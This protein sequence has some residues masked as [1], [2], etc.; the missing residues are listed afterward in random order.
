MDIDL[1]SFLE[2]PY[3]DLE[4][5]NLVAKKK[6]VSRVSQKELRKFYTTYLSEEIRIKAVTIG[7]SDIEGRLH[8]LDY[9]KKYFLTSIP[10]DTTSV[11]RS[12]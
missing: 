11:A 5:M 4:A 1:K 2:I 6:R 7:F 9:D 12:T 3:T 10:R 8:M